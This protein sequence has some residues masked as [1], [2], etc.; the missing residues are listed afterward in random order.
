MIDAVA[1]EA[2]E[3]YTILTGLLGQIAGMLQ[4]ADVVTPMGNTLVSNVPGP[5]EMLYLQG[6]PCVEMHPVSTLP[7]THL[8]LLD[9]D[10]NECAPGEVGEL[11][12]A[13]PYLF[14]GYL[15][16]PEATAK[17]MRGDWF[18][19]ASIAVPDWTRMF[20]RASCVLS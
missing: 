15:N 16:M 20:Q 1:P 11:A 14:A 5:A 9:D 6:A 10:G 17:S 8:R 18:A 12:V 2:V 7:A 19:C 3:T 13:S 4:L